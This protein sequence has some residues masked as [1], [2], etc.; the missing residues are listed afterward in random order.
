LNLFHK[1]ITLVF[2]S[3]FIHQI[4]VSQSVLINK[5]GG[6]PD[7]S[8][9][10]ELRSSEKGFLAP[11]ME[12][13]D[14][15]SIPTPATGLLVFQTNGFKG[16]YFYNGAAWDT[17][18]ITSNVTYVSNVVNVSNS[19]ITLISDIKPINTN[20]GKF[21]SGAW[22]KRDLNTIS[23]DLAKVSLLNDTISIDSGIYLITV[24][25][26]AFGV[27]E[28]QA[29][30]FNVTKN[31]VSGSGTMSYSNMFA[32]S[33]SQ[34]S[35]IVEVGISGE[36]FIVQHRCTTTSTLNTGFGKGSTWSENVYTQVQI[37]KL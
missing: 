28:H 1:I 25:A 4:G 16:F 8:A 23:G 33:S 5:D 35:I 17:L 19:G 29:R 18:G 20:G 13:T 26:P 34:M 27:D 22:Q 6:N 32:S 12:A 9:I 11:R 15:L 24:S 37:Q 10:L 31:S 3:L 36:L 7:N 30:L 14:R 2:F 21:T